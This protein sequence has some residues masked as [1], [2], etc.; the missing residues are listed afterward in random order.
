MKKEEMDIIKKA[1]DHLRELKE[2]GFYCLKRGH[3]WGSLEY[4]PREKREKGEEERD[5]D[6]RR[7]DR[8][9]YKLRFIEAGGVVTRECSVCHKVAK[10]RLLE[11]E[12]DRD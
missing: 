8:S 4:P 3:N 9:Y 1:E 7:F 12:T 10:L 6:S 2:S 11:H 5:S